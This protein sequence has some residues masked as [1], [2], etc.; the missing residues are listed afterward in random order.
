MS[1]R[2]KLTETIIANLKTEVEGFL[3]WLTPDD[4]SLD[5]LE[6]RAREF[7]KVCGG[8]VFKAGLDS[9]LEAQEFGYVGSTAE[10]PGGVA[11]FER[12]APRW[13][14]TH[15]G[16]FRIKRAY[17]WDAESRT[18]RLPLD[19][20]WELDEREP[21]PSL[22]RSI[23]MLGAEVPFARAR[24]LRLQRNLRSLGYRRNQR[25]AP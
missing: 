25:S 21:S 8:I 13:I 10:G 7:A 18:G 14:S 15:L 23:G 4:E 3:D 20:R 22:R 16:R 12:Y 5:G 2:E 9:M 6:E 1:T 11:F 17:Y 24:R 19:E